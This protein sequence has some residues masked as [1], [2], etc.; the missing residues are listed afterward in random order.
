MDSDPNFRIVVYV[1]GQDDVL[2][3]APVG[4]QGGFLVAIYQ[5]DGRFSTLAF[6]ISG[7]RD[8]VHLIVEVR[9]RNGVLAATSH[10][11]V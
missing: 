10:T 3:L 11:N 8:G 6:E 1:D 9:N 5:L 2:T 4:E 7:R